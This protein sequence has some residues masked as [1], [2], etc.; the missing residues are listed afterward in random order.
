MTI[1]RERER[2]LKILYCIV[3]SPCWMLY[4]EIYLHKPSQSR[5]IPFL[6]WFG[7]FRVSD[8]PSCYRIKTFTHQ[9]KQSHIFCLAIN[10]IV[11]TVTCTDALEEFNDFPIRY[12][13]LLWQLYLLD[14]NLLSIKFSSHSVRQR[15]FCSRVCNFFIQV[16]QI[17]SK[18]GLTEALK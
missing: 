1:E 6:S 14:D 17:W 8:L 16:K 9:E 10:H 18:T 3:V 2:Q 13:I 5:I 15:C 11:I 7:H 12:C 4:C